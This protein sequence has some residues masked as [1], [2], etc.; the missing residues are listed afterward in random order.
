MN[1]LIGLL[2][3]ALTLGLLAA[4]PAHVLAVHAGPETAAA[5]EQVERVDIN[6]ASTEELEKVPGIGPATAA[7]IVEWRETH[8]RFERVE[9]LLNIRGIGT[10]TLERLRPYLEVRNGGDGRSA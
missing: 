6:T 1:K 9:D 7:R 4:A 10:K 5:Q 2:T 8:G 3:T